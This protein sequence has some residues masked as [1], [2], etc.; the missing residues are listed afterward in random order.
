MLTQEKQHVLDP[1]DPFS[2]CSENPKNHVEVLDEFVHRC[3]RRLFTKLQKLEVLVLGKET[4]L[5]EF[6]DL[7]DGFVYPFGLR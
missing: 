3:G 6:C 1:Q 5:T 4:R 2:A 7:S